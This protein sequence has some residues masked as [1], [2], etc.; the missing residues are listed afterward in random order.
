MFYLQYLYDSSF[1][2]FWIMFNFSF[3]LSENY[4]HIPSLWI[5]M[6]QWNYFRLKTGI[7]DT[8][9]RQWSG[10]EDINILN[11]S[12][13]LL[14]FA[15]VFK[16]FEYFL[17]FSEFNDHY[18]PT[19]LFR[20]CRWLFDRIPVTK[21]G[22]DFF[23]AKSGNFSFQILPFSFFFYMICLLTRLEN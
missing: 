5:F 2:N 10:F 13:I 15:I 21:K 9:L 19:K 22:F 8:L 17:S 3:N 1:S 20:F 11:L 6:S 12:K 18:W 4:Y 7:L 14:K 23:T 16:M